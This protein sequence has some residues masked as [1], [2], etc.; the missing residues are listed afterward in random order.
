[1]TLT[2]LP[3]SRQPANG[4]IPPPR[5]GQRVRAIPLQA[6]LLPGGGI[7][8]SSPLARGWAGHAR[9]AVELANTLAHAFTEVEIAGYAMAHGANYDQDRLTEQVEGDALA[10]TKM[11]RRRGPVARRAAHPPEA[12]S[13]H[14]DGSWRSPA[15][16]RYPPDSPHVQRV[17]AKLT[18]KGAMVDTHK[19]PGVA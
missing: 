16:R 10:G 1:V 14:H 19:E 17:I 12:W 7:R 18:A 5:P 3:P 6:E 13:M 4:R 11:A 9:T 8:I 2:N 15:G